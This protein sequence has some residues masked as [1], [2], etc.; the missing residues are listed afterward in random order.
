M[1][2]YIDVCHIETGIELRTKQQLVQLRS[3]LTGLFYH[4]FCITHENSVGL[5][6]T[7]TISLK[8]EVPGLQSQVYYLEAKLKKILSNFSPK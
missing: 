4:C 6:S 7:C 8:Q 1:F 5:D 2:L 3:G